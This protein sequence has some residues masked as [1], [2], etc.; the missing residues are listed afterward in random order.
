MPSYSSLFALCVVASGIVG[1]TLANPLAARAKCSPNFEGAGISILGANGFVTPDGRGH[2]SNAPY[3]HIQQNGQSVPGYTFRDIANDNVAL[4]RNP[5]NSLT[6]GAVANS[7]NDVRQT[8]NIE[9]DT[10]V[11]GAATAPPMTSIATGCNIKLNADPTLC[12]QVGRAP[13]DDLN[14]AQCGAIPG[15]Q[16]FSF[17]T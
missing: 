17:S 10:C 15:S 9:C 7:G 5:D 11:G 14:L 6:M 4:T 1:T 3:W 2:G 16:G 12:V 13:S 8:F